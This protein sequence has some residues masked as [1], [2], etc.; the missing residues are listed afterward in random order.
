MKEAVK[1]FADILRTAFGKEKKKP[2][3]TAIIVAAGNSTRMKSQT[4]KQF[5]ILDGMPV[6][7]RTLRAFEQAK[8]IDKII[9]VAK[10]EDHPQILTLCNKYNIKKPYKLVTGGETRQD[11]V[12]CGFKKISDNTNFVAIHDG[13]R[14]LITPHDIDRVCSY[15]YKEGAAS[16][17]TPVTDTV[18]M[19]S[20]Q[21]FIDY[22]TQLDRNKIWLVQ[23]PQVFGVN[24]YRAAAYTA[25]ENG[26]IATDDN[27]LVEN[28]KYNIKLVPCRRDNIKITTSDDLI[29][30]KLYIDLY[31]ETINSENP[32]FEIIDEEKNSD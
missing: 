13:A 17:A 12:L 24:L 26:F 14:C 32:P 18:K 21:N 8:T 4:S 7:A 25:K 22:D 15:A 1:A 30:A 9:I 19:T 20:S 11:S 31:S 27:A 3:T 23:T 2:M 29:L 16:A 6:L 10:E 28:I 5:L